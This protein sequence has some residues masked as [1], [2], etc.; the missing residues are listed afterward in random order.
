MST[1]IRYNGVNPLGTRTPFVST[2]VV[3]S[4]N[5][6]Y[7]SQTDRYTISG[8][9][10]RPACNTNFAAYKADIDYICSVFQLQFKPFEVIQDGVVIF[11]NEQSIIRSITFPESSFN[12]FYNYEIVID[13]IRSFEGLGIVDP[14]ETYETSQG[15]SPVTTIKHTISCRGVGPGEIAVDNAARFVEERR[16]GI[17]PVAFAESEENILYPATLSRVYSLNRSTGEV[18]LVTTYLYNEEDVDPQYSYS[19]LTYTCELSENPEETTITISG[20]MQGNAVDGDDEMEQARYRFEQTDWQAIAQ[21]EWQ[22]FGGTTL[23]GDHTQFSVNENPLT[24]EV[25][26]TLVWNTNSQEGAYLQE[27][28]TILRSYEGEPTC[29]RYQAVAKTDFGCVGQKFAAVKALA[30]STNFVN[31]AQILWNKY[32][33]GESLS[34]VARSQSRTESPFAGTI[35]FEITYCHENSQS[36]GCIEN[37]TYTLSFVE[38]IELYVSQ[39]LLRGMGIYATQDLGIKN[40]AKFSIQGTARRAK[41]FTI[42]QARANIRTRINFI[43]LYYFPRND[44]ILEEAQIEMT[45]FGDSISFNYS[46]SG[47]A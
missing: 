44:K 5:N 21:L 10:P 3:L 42:E 25:S 16:I 35:S 11:R 2:E 34:T 30:D 33:T 29:F 20:N 43:S 40:R 45:E 17:L 26:F 13:C 32:G 4:D 19:V 28:W 31:R 38:P 47:A 27:N 18:S 23:L 14:Q 12:S 15:D 22:N 9:R 41:C 7:V 24:A 8:S 39:P 36:C 46:W 37:F 6:G 1:I